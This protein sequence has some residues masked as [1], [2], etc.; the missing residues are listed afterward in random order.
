MNREL[1]SGLKGRIRLSVDDIPCKV[2]Y[3]T[4]DENRSRRETI[5]DTYQSNP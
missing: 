4:R 2:D 5:I 1:K 3:R